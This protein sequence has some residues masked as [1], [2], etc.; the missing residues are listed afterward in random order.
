MQTRLYRPRSGEGP[1]QRKLVPGRYWSSPIT[2]ICER[3]GIPAGGRSAG[4]GAFGGG[5]SSGT[6]ILGA[7]GGVL[8]A[9]GGAA[10]SCPAASRETGSYPNQ[11]VATRS[12]RSRS[13]GPKM[14]SPR[15]ISRRYACARPITGAILGV[16]RRTGQVPAFFRR[17]PYVILGRS[18]SSRSC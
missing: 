5:M 15:L 11:T 1:G 13:A 3:P 18:S 4:V 10:F 16:P 14:A 9:G 6:A 7:A 8:G 2:S 12:R 17:L